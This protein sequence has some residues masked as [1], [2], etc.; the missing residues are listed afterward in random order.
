M[1]NAARTL[2][3]GA[4]VVYELAFA[5]RHSSYIRVPFDSLL[6]ARQI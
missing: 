5:R 4:V 6:P 1:E 2:Y 3:D